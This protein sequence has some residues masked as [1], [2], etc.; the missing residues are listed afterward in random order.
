MDF[1]IVLDEGGVVM[2]NQVLRAGSG[3]EARAV[4]I[5]QG[6]IGER[7]AGPIAEDLKS[8]FALLGR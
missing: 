6:E 1:E 3:G 4:E 2:D 5:Y 7:V 8:P